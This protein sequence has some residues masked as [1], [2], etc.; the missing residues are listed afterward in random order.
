[1]S[2]VKEE[3]N[4]MKRKF[5]I[6]VLSKKEMGSEGK[7]RVRLEGASTITLK[8]VSV[9]IR[10]IGDHEQVLSLG[11]KPSNFIVGKRRWN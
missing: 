6:G 3:R 9:M 7:G 8:T 11:I 4:E 1:M 2:R 10:A 5:R